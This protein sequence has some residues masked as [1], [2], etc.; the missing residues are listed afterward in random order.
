MPVMWRNRL[1]LRAGPLTC[2]LNICRSPVVLSSSGYTKK[3]RIKFLIMQLLCT[4]DPGD[5]GTGRP[6]VTTAGP[7]TT[8][9]WAGPRFVCRKAPLLILLHLQLPGSPIVQP[10]GPQS[11]LAQ[12]E[13]GICT[14]APWEGGTSCPFWPS[15]SSRST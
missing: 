10:A 14:T 7:P 1:L 12:H 3:N 15:W 8:P 2:S 4:A 11:Q 9:L 13:V 6:L 5:V